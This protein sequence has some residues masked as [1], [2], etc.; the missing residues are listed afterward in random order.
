M[1]CVGHHGSETTGRATVAELL[2]EL[3]ASCEEPVPRRDSTP[4]SGVPPRG[5]AKEGL[6]GS[7]PGEAS[8]TGVGS[9]DVF[10][11]GSV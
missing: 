2:Q 9:G 7:D 4:T 6:S 5:A 8:G 11:T 1:H 10:C 3:F